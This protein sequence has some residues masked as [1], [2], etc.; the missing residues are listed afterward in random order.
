MGY[1]PHTWVNNHVPA[2][3]ETHLNEMEAGIDDA[4]TLL[5]PASQMCY[6]SADFATD[7][8]YLKFP[9]I[10]DAID[11]IHG[12]S[13]FGNLSE[14]NKAMVKVGPGKYTEQ[15]HSYEHIIIASHTSG[16]DTIDTTPI[17][18]LYNTG[19]DSAHYPL[20]SDE[21]E[22]YTIVG[23]NIETE[24]DGVIGKIPN[25]NFYS[26]RFNNGYFIE[27]NSTNVI[28][29]SNCAFSGS[30]YAGF[31]FTGTNLLGTRNIILRGNCEVGTQATPQLLSTHVSWANFKC[32]DVDFS[33]SVTI[34][35]DWDWRAKNCHS[36]RIVQR[37][38][39][40]TTGLINIIDSTMSNGLHF[41]SNPA[42]FKMVNSSFEGISDNKIP[43]GEADITA[44]VPIVDS[45][46]VG[47]TQHNGICGCMQIQCPIKSVGGSSFNRYFNLQAAIDSIAV[48]GII[49]LHESFTDLAELVIT[50]GTTVHIDGNK[51][52]SLSF[53]IDIVEIGPGSKFGF[54]DMVQISGGNAHLNGLGAE[55]SFESC[56]YMV[57]YV[58]IDLGAFA[59]MYKSSMFGSTGKKAVYMNNTDTP[60][61]FGYSRIQG[62]TGNP[63][64]EINAAADTKLKAKFSTFIHGDKTD[65]CPISQ[66][67]GG[68]LN[69]ALYLCGVNKLWASPNPFLNVITKAGIVDDTEINF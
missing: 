68:S 3:N 48:E 26:C 45:I 8:E 65:V 31:Y 44:D 49:D 22:N 27:R 50:D 2:L 51:V 35:G 61:V 40:D 4:H 46:Y 16:F 36:F 10:Q 14:S 11:A 20:R 24:V 15:I 54:V 69:I 17:T 1:N 41:I 62:S 66:T 33:G 5:V 39:I 30:S 67:V 32:T 42:S 9:K 23:I 7:T 58:T 38:I 57:G 59:I 63:A 55:I 28:I 47:N 12:A 18:T 13:W 43:D 6:V 29:F 34:K 52:Y 37:N 25:G 53:A 19:A 64:V 21:D 56:Q 60:V